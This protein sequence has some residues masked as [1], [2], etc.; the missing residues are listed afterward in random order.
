M[1]QAV[2]G[3]GSLLVAWVAL[4]GCSATDPFSEPLDEVLPRQGAVV[5]EHPLATKAGLL[6]LEAGGNAADAAVAAAL[7][8]AVVFPQAGN[9]G[10]GGFAVWVPRYEGEGERAT[11]LDFREVAPAGYV[12]A[13]YLGADGEVVPER[14]LRTPLAVGVP[15]TPAGLYE[16][17]RRHG[18]KNIGFARLCE[19]AIRLAEGGIP[20][21]PWL[22]Q[23]LA[24]PGKRELLSADP[25][26]R[27]LFYPDGEPLQAGDILVQPELGRTLRLLA[28]RGARGFY[29]GAVVNA[30]LN[31]L[32]DADARAGGVAGTA[33]MTEEDLS[34]YEPR[35]REP[36]RAVYR[37]HEVIGMPP[38]SSGGVALIQTL[39][40]L[41]G[42]PLDVVRQNAEERVELGLDEPL[43]VGAMGRTRDGVTGQ[44][45]A[46]I[47]AHAVH[48][49]IE[50]MRL[51][52]ADRAMHL[53][54]PDSHDV[55]TEELIGAAWIADRR[56]SISDQANLDARPWDPAMALPPE[57]DET[58]HIS[59]ID[60][61]GNAVSLTTTLNGTFGSGIFVDAA[62][63]LLNN[64]LD[65]FSILPGTP[66]MFGLVGSEANQLAPGRRPLS[67]MCPVVVRGPE[68]DVRL[69][70]GAPGG[71]R[72]ITAVTQ[73]LL[74]IVGYG[75]GLREAIRA[76][77]IHQ[78]WRPEET[79]FESGWD[80]RLI[81]AL[82]DRHGQ[83]VLAPTSRVFGSVQG[84]HVQPDGTV[85]AY[86]DPRRGGAG[87]LE[88]EEPAL[89][90]LV[91]D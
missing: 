39:G 23:A 25:G 73:V 79:R 72:I 76:P 57:S 27:R 34:G 88:G 80:P 62:G 16:L 50:A 44:A 63:F 74:R 43:T 47:D 69:V 56:V 90:A 46:G 66:N 17:F 86:S 52:F 22:A 24:A 10:G 2:R 37:G 11:A 40:I 45:W 6:V 33:L 51:A 78:Q 77:R 87:G 75:Q 38:P 12:Q 1:A 55:P 89:P 58:T 82:K 15:G 42:L 21:D 30:I 68:R 7:T 29:S 49:W 13:L 41:E 61:D 26:A 48:Y 28:K 5:T 18:S 19:S 84:I 54:D 67:S 31:D 71:P 14:S 4:S 9:L 3:A 35:W 20:V 8:L 85:E 60:R 70:L 36:L 81:D 83:P 32:K 64:E 65:D 59:V 53:G 91:R